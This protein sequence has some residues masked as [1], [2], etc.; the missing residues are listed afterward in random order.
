MDRDP[1]AAAAP[2][3]Q[4]LHVLAG[5]PRKRSAALADYPAAHVHLLL[6]G[7]SKYRTETERSSCALGRRPRPAATVSGCW[8]ATS[9]PRTSCSR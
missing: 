7:D 2:P 4:P 5:A 6:D 8:C 9:T 1:A 3:D